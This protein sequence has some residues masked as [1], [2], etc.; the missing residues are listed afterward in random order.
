M[1]ERLSVENNGCD[2][3]MVETLADAGL[4]AIQQ[5]CIPG[6]T[7]PSEVLSASFTIL[8]RILRSVGKMQTT[9]E[10]LVNSKEI[11]RILQEFIVD[12]GTVPS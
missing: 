8:D 3:T 4:R 6:V 1:T 5:A 2:D 7:T 9:E 11:S 10:R 12:H